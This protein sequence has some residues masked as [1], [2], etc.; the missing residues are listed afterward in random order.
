MRGAAR[1]GLVLSRE[2][3]SDALEELGLPADADI[4][5]EVL[6]LE[7]AKMSYEK[8]LARARELA[9][10]DPKAVAQLIKEWMGGGSGEGH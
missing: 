4:P 8:K 3:V 5:P 2:A 7:L 9:K 10:K 6:E 1:A